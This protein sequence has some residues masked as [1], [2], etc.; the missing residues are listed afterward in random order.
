MKFFS[1]HNVFYGTVLLNHN[2]FKVTKS[3]KV[4]YNPFVQGYRHSEVAHLLYPLAVFASEI[5]FGVL[6]HSLIKS[7]LNN[8]FINTVQN[9]VFYAPWTITLFIPKWEIVCCFSRLKLSIVV[10]TPHSTN[11]I[12]AGHS[13]SLTS[14]WGLK[15]Q[16]HLS[17]ISSNLY[18]FVLFRDHYF[19]R[20]VGAQWGN[21]ALLTKHL[22]VKTDTDL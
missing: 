16:R 12:V 14:I 7:L 21:T 11:L 4:F 9:E 6:P 2:K 1:R 5:S 3:T 8:T 19:S 18:P 10:A 22:N 15:Y 20:S 13:S 17:L